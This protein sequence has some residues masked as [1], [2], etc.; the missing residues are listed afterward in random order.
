MDMP[1]LGGYVHIE[2]GKNDMKCEI[3]TDDDKTHCIEE[4]NAHASRVFGQPVRVVNFIGEKPCT[5][6]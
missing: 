4:L 5:T 3:C 2:S 6:S 1:K